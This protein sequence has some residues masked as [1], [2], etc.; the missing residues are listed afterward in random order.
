VTLTGA[1]LTGATGVNVARVGGGGGGGG[2]TVTN[3]AV[4]STGTH[5][6]ATFT[7]DPA[8][9]IGDRNVSVTSARGNSGPVTFHVF[10]PPAPTLASISPTSA[11]RGSPSFTVAFTGTN[12]A[13]GAV[14]VVRPGGGGQNFVTVSN[15]TVNQAG[16]GLT[17]TFAI[18]GGAALGPRNV[19]VT[20]GGGTTAT[21]TFTVN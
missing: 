17:A 15:V 11:T 1:N 19:S 18:A 21:K 4:D 6:T 8:T 16:N 2:V 9:A 13:G 14:N 10:A 3:I 7:I 20:T 12:L 5:L